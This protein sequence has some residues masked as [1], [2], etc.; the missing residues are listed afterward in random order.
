METVSTSMQSNIDSTEDNIKEGCED[1]LIDKCV[2]DFFDSFLKSVT[3][4]GKSMIPTS[5]QELARWTGRVIFLMQ[6]FANK[7]TRA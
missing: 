6:A 4:D 7:R 1:R 5:A 2:G 3:D